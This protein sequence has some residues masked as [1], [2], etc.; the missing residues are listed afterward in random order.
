MRRSNVSSNNVRN[1]M[2]TIG[3]F[4]FVILYVS[5]TFLYCASNVGEEIEEIRENHNV[6]HISVLLWDHDPNWWDPY[7]DMNKC[8]LPCNLVTDKEKIATVSHQ[9]EDDKMY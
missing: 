3:L 7:G 4:A 5:F 2:A 1:S 6:R 9:P 8:A